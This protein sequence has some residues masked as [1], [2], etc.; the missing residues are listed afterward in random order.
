MK[1]F[2]I[3]LNIVLI[4]T[5]VLAIS[6]KPEVKTVSI[7]TISRG[8][9][10]S[11][12]TGIK[13]IENEEKQVEEE[14]QEEDVNVIDESVSN[15]EE[16]LSNNIASASIVTDVLETQVGTMSAY[17]L[18]CSGCSGRVGASY[19][20]AGNNVRYNDPT[21]GECR[22]IAADPKYPYGTIIRVKDSKIGTFNAIVLDRGGAIGIGRRY[23]VDLLFYT[24]AEASGFGLSRD[25][26]FEVLRYGY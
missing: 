16:D 4:I 12:F 23:M 3:I 25:T 24:E 2:Y 1:R 20:A 10:T 18:D 5:I 15:V 13:K 9:T 14:K 6:L 26:T 22:I 19:D 21:Y 11:T 7:N 17:G 8:T